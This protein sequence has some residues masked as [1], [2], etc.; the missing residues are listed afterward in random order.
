MIKNFAIDLKDY[1]IRN[2]IK[3]KQLWTVYLV[4]NQR[5]KINYVAKM[6]K[7]SI[8]DK[9]KENFFISQIEN[10]SLIKNP[11][12]LPLFGYS[13]LNF[14][15]KPYPTLIFNY[16]PNGSLRSIFEKGK[17]SNIPAEWTTTTK[18]IILLGIS[19]G[20]KYLHSKELI[21]L[22]LN[23]DNILLDDHFYPRINNFCLTKNP[24]KQMS[25]IQKRSAIERTLYSAPEIFSSGRFNK[26]V[27]VYSFSLI[28]YQL[29][30]NEKPP[31]IYSVISN[32]DVSELL[33]RCSS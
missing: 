27:D 4:E 8:D 17:Q 5:T 6:S 29:I 19:L 13:K 24:N 3:D 23:P 32:D 28:A 31:I 15:L 7:S 12:I 1:K 20:M 21:H 16:F 2:I 14:N 9:E 11:A 25:E 26:T 10:Y 30:T 18:Y 22:N 33:R